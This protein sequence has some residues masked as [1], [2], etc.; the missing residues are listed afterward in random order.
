M[1]VTGIS[2]VDFGFTPALAKIA[3]AFTVTAIPRF[4]KNLIKA[5]EISKYN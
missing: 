3:K 1:A 4:T 2:H 5:I